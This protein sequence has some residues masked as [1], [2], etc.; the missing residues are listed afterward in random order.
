MKVLN[1]GKMRGKERRTKWDE[2][3]VLRR[4]FRARE[5]GVVKEVLARAKVVLCTLHGAG[6]R[7]L[8]DEAEFDVIVIDEA[9][10]AVEPACWIPIV[11]GRKLILVS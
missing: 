3:K 5:G 2:V 4:E 10:Q 7:M 1:N 11:R 8:R 6:N 9:A